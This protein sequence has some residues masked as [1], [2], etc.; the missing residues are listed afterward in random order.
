MRS[1]RPRIDAH[2]TEAANIGSISVDHDCLDNIMTFAKKNREQALISAERLDI[3]LLQG[4]LRHEHMEKHK[5]N[6]PGKSIKTPQISKRISKI[7]DKK[8]N[9]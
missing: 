2:Y 6:G 3:L 9:W 7:Q 5:K 8:N 4:F 1:K